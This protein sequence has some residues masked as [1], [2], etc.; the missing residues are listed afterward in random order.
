[1]HSISTPSNNYAQ[2]IPKP[3]VGERT[4]LELNGLACL[5]L[6][7]VAPNKQQ[8]IS[9]RSFGTY[10]QSLPELM[11][12]VAL[13]MSRAAEKLRQQGSLAGRVQV[14]IRTNPFRAHTTQY[15]RDINIPLPEATDDT[16]RLIRAAHWGLKR[17][18][19]TG[20]DYQKAGVA[21]LDL[22]PM[23]HKQMTLFPARQDRRDLMRVMDRINALYGRG[24]L[25]SGAEG[26]NPRWRTK[27]EHQSPAYT[28]CWAELASVT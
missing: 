27:R 8:I 13:Y 9:S 25:K 19:R 28:T 18:Y 15:Q 7:T 14:H 4:V 2:P 20:L 16:L 26:L 1:M 6:E 10:V 5:D 23:E 17:I 12:A 22:R 21:L 24:T 11:E 3:C